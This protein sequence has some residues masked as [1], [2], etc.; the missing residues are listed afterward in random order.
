MMTT[1]FMLSLSC[2]GQQKALNIPGLYQ[3]VDAS[4]SENKL[5]V[6]AK[7]EQL[8][9]NSQEY[10]NK[11]LLAKLKNKYRDLQQRYQTLGTLVIAANIGINATPMV[12]H[13]IENQS[14]IYQIASAHP[15]YLLLAYQTEIEFATKA[16]SLLNYLLGLTAS[17]GAV[18]QM[19]ISDRKIL[20]DFILTELNTIESLSFTL[21]NSLQYTLVNGLFK[22]L[23][24]FQGFVDQDKDIVNDIINN[25]KYLKQ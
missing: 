17:L 6:Q 5:Q 4:K 23:N 25:A 16:R 10:E 9:V 18:N 19:K 22:T 7:N 14:A 12:N 24:P 11:T 8:V 20:F 15:V 21:L 2:Y 1:L 3:L 13:I